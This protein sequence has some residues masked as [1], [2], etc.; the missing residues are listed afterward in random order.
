MVRSVDSGG[1]TVHKTL[2]TAEALIETLRALLATNPSVTLEPEHR[3]H[4]APARAVVIH[5]LAE[6]F[7]QHLAT[8]CPRCGT[9]EFGR[10]DVEP[11]LRWMLLLR[12]RP[13]R[14]TPGRRTMVRPLQPVR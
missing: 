10:I 11:R 2:E 3:A 9:P 8:D 5:A 4:A 1:I 13:R 14:A 7:T 12:M 6:R